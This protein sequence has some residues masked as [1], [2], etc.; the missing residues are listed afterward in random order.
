[1]VLF[2]R[3]TFTPSEV[4]VASRQT[5]S[6]LRSVLRAM[7]HRESS[8]ICSLMI[9]LPLKNCSHVNSFRNEGNYSLQQHTRVPTTVHSVNNGPNGSI[10]PAWPRDMTIC[11]RFAG[12]AITGTQAHVQVQG[13]LR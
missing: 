7:K 11:M 5:A 12:D 8:P 1:M 2:T 4:H 6:D 10:R 3:V 13:R 9:V